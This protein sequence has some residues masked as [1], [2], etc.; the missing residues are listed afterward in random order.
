MK[1][2]YKKELR[3]VQQNAE[4]RREML[5]KKAYG[6]STLKRKLT[7]TSGILALFSAGAITTVLIKII[8]NSGIQ[9]IAAISAALSGA[10]S[11]I[12]T[13]YSDSEVNNMYEG[14]A[15]YLEIRERAGTIGL[16]PKTPDEEV[17]NHINA[18]HDQYN[19]CDIKYSK[20]FTLYGGSS[21]ISTIT[22][23]RNIIRQI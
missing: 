9:M 12:S 22:G 13:S 6:Q 23:S 17:I 2:E 14:A 7:L 15:C 19:K 10:I 5:L 16:I 1:Q 4:M 3:R 11:L 21:N 18:L 20:Y 8:G